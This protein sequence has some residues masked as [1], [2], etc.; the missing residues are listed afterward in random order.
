MWFVREYLPEVFARESELA[1][2]EA[3]VEHFGAVKIETLAVPA[4][5]TD[6]VF[7]AY[8]QRP[9]AYLDPGIRSAI[10]GIALLD[11]DVVEAAVA[12]LHDDLDSGQWA[13]THEELLKLDEIDLGYRLV[14]AG[15]MLARG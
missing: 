5:C 14:I 13:S 3:I 10:S 7:G 6:G 2:L 4:D 1:T 11:Q 15:D 8:W 12:R 9:R